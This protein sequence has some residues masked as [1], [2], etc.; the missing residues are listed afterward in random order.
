[1]E[2]DENVV[3]LIEW[4]TTPEWC[5]DRVGVVMVDGS[6][7]LVLLLAG[8]MFTDCNLIAVGFWIAP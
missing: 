6:R 4:C 7:S 1:M 3:P 2:Y 5:T 8:G